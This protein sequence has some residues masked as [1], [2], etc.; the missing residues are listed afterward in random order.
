MALEVVKYY[1]NAY[2]PNLCILFS[3]ISVY[4][5]Q[6]AFFKESLRLEIISNIIKST[7]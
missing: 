4:I 1:C 6:S 7:L 5:L 2:F 3:L